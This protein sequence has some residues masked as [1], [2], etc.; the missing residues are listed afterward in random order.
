[1]RFSLNSLY[2]TIMPPPH[3]APSANMSAACVAAMFIVMT[4]C[5]S[6]EEPTQT[7]RGPVIVQPIAQDNSEY[8]IKPGYFPLLIDIPWTKLGN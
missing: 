8:W 3:L 7:R 4:T 6:A 1:M 2:T 5:L